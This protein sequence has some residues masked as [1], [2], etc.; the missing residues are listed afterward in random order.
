TQQ[1]ST[2]PDTAHPAVP[3]A[4]E[5]P[6][7]WPQALWDRGAPTIQEIADSAFVRALLD[8]SRP[9]ASFALYLNQD[10]LYLARYSRALAAVAASSSNQEAQAFWAGGATNCLTVE[11]ELH[12]AWLGDRPG[13]AISPVTSAYTN[14]LLASALGED[15]VVGSAAVLPCYWLY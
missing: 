3:A 13:A 11:S 12:R 14:F 8:G 4:V 9:E 7:P 15:T 5:P 2:Q 6:G 10:A 1:P